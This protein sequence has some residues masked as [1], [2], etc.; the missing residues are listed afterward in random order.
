MSEREAVNIN[1]LY[2]KKKE[3]EKISWLTAYDYP[4]AS[5]QEE[6]GIEMILVGDSG[7][8]TLLGYDSTLPV[9]MDEMMVMTKAVT[10]ATDK[11]FVVGDMPYMSYQPGKE[12]AIKNAGR[13]M[14]E[15][16]TDAIKLEGGRRM[17]PTVEA[18][19]DA[20]IPV[21]GHIGMTPQSAAQLGGYK[22]QGRDAQS[23]KELI[24]D[25]KSL[26]QA[27]AFAILLEAVP[28]RV[29]KMIYDQSDVPIYGIGAG[30]SVDGQLLIVQDIL[31]LFE[32]FKPR[33]VKRYANLGEEMVDA[34]NQ[35]IEEVKSGEFPGEEHCY[36]IPDEEFRE[37]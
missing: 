7:G 1:Y 34:F 24:E 19:V 28:S 35:Y 15:C 21:I 31:G 30:S 20:G 2:Q 32:L 37:I 36:K 18:I 3:G 10:R 25:A 14:G 26:E 8:M 27:G 13:F 22:S 29:A 6:A 4:T 9:S 12:E 17:A 23:A 11:T 33:F 16:G 5:F